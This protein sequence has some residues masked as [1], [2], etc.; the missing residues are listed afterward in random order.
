MKPK[1]STSKILKLANDPKLDRL[2]ESF[3]R[4]TSVALG[5]NG[6]EFQQLFDR[7]KVHLPEQ[8]DFDTLFRLDALAGEDALRALRAGFVCGLLCD[9]RGASWIHNR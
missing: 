8:S 1:H 5:E 9:R 2:L 7:I 3:E 4:V 6:R